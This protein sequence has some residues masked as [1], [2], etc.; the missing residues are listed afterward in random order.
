MTSAATMPTFTSR[1]FLQ[2]IESSATASS[3]GDIANMA[4]ASSTRLK[5]QG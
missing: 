1:P 4:A 5:R 2:R 3:A